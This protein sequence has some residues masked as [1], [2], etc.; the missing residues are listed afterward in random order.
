MLIRVVYG[1]ARAHINVSAPVY[2]RV[3]VNRF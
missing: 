3:K 2:A 1:F